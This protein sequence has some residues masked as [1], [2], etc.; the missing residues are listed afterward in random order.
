MLLFLLLGLVGIGG[1]SWAGSGVPGS[2]LDCEGGGWDVFFLAAAE[3]RA[4][5]LKDWHD[6]GTG[7]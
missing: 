5:S 7:F 1:S 2:L 3:A 6:G 4:A